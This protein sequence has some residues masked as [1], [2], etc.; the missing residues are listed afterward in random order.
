[1]Q[2]T[3][4]LDETNYLHHQ[5]FFASQSPTIRKRRF[6]A[7]FVFPI[8]YVLLGIFLYFFKAPVMGYIFGGIG[9]LWFFLYPIYEKGAYIKSYK[10]FIRENFQNTVDKA[11]TLQ[12]E[13]NYF[14]LKDD[15]NEAKINLSELQ[16]IAEIPGEILIKIGNGNSIIIP[17][18]QVAELTN[19]E[20]RLEEIAERL[21]ID[22]LDYSQWTWK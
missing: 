13:D 18:N 2:I 7:K 6:R 10:K 19:L 21:Q 22:Y 15:G 14:I 1:M 17:K 5:L 12:I 3:F 20:N 16:E 11:I 9:I 8:V 4:K